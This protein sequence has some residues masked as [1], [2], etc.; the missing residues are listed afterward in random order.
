MT[1]AIIAVI[2]YIAIIAVILAALR[3]MNGSDTDAT[4]AADSV[5]QALDFEELRTY[6]TN[7]VRAGT[8]YGKVIK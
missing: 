3:K 1:A 5:R 2:G 8:A 7:H 4:E 6:T